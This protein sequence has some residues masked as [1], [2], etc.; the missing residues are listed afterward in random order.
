M[1]RSKR[2]GRRR[3][4]HACLLQHTTQPRLCGACTAAQMLAGAMLLLSSLT[5]PEE[6]VC[7]PIPAAVA[8]S[9]C[10]AQAAVAQR[11]RGR[12]AEGTARCGHSAGGKFPL[13]EERI[14]CGRA[15]VPRKLISRGAEL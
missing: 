15:L 3:P 10:A 13:L 9:P 12:G 8:P 5:V 6:G 14:R 4:I 7:G 2:A 1:L 11:R